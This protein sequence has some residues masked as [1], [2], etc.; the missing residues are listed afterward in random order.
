M[1][2]LSDMIYRPVQ[3]DQIQKAEQKTTWFNQRPTLGKHLQMVL[4]PQSLPTTVG[5]SLDSQESSAYEIYSEHDWY[6]HQSFTE[7][8]HTTD[9]KCT[10]NYTY[11]RTAV[12][13]F[14]PSTHWHF[15]WATPWSPQQWFHYS[16]W[17][18]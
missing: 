5:P 2:V 18:L 14:R 12:I 4:Q 8:P 13:S 16:P 7:T 1:Q 17:S 3:E 15:T 9:W 6:I 10:P 11:I